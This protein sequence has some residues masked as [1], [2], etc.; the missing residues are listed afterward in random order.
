L[1]G[2][3]D[4]NFRNM[5]ST[6]VVSVHNSKA[7]IKNQKYIQ[8]ADLIS[9]LGVAVILMN[10]RGRKRARHFL[11]PR[12]SILVESGNVTLTILSVSF[13]YSF[14]GNAPS[15]K[16]IVTFLVALKFTR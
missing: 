12:Y 13:K 7:F 2:R 11:S 10:V 3:S 9:T 6:Y 15:L 4:K 14:A 8:R 1:L 5:K 16:G